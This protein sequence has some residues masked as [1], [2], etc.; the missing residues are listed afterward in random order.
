MKLGLGLEDYR[1]LGVACVVRRHELDYLAATYAGEHL[2]AATWISANDGRLSLWRR[3]Q[4]IRLADRK[5]VL[6]ARSHFVCV[7]MDNGRPTRMPPEFRAVYRV[8]ID[9][10]L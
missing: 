4:I 8:M 9:E 6:R 7:R 3:Y 5:T 1:R 10:A 2:V